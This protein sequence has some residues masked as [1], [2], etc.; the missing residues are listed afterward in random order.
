M[1]VEQDEEMATDDS[2][3]HDNDVME[4]VNPSPQ[5]TQPRNGLHYL[6]NSNL[7]IED[8]VFLLLLQDS[9]EPY[10]DKRTGQPYKRKPS[11]VYYDKST[12]ILYNMIVVYYILKIEQ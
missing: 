9:G 5:R 1:N 7:L 12:D 10:I 6:E 11:K 3:S 4:V 2:S 8:K